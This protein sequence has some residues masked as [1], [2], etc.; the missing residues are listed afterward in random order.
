M[1]PSHVNLHEFRSFLRKGR[2]S[3]ASCGARF[4]AVDGPTAARTRSVLQ[5]FD[6]RLKVDRVLPPGTADA[7]L[8]SLTELVSLRGDA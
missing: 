3:L 7:Y 2:N 1:A 8:G 5:S 4:P 6:C